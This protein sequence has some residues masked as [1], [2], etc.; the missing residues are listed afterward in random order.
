[1]NALEEAVS[2]SADDILDKVLLNLRIED[3]KFLADLGNRVVR[4]EKLVRDSKGNVWA[5]YILD[6]EVVTVKKYD[7]D[8]DI[9]KE[10][11]F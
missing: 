8:R 11:E 7:A 5:T 3:G 2:S 10:R 6:G 9:R 4:M 1:M